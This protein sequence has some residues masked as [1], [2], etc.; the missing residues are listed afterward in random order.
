M[1]NQAKLRSY[2][3][4][5]QCMNGFEVPRNYKHA[6]YLDQRNRNDRWKV[7]TDL[8]FTQMDEYDAFHDYGKGGKPPSNEYKRIRVHLVYAVKHDGRHKARCV[9]DGHLTEVPVESVYSGVVSL[10]G[11]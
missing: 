3:N 6:M 2:R 1:A 10:R 7:A 8:E 11:L 5:P 9:A 4:A